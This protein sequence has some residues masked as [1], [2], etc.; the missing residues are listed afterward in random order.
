MLK[1]ITALAMSQFCSEDI[2]KKVRQIRFD[3]QSL[4][5]IKKLDYKDI[6]IGYAA[7][8]TYITLSRCNNPK[9]DQ[10]FRDYFDVLLQTGIKVTLAYS[11]LLDTFQ[12]DRVYVFN[13]RMI[14]SR[15][16]LEVTLQRK[17]ALYCMEVYS[18]EKFGSFRKIIFKNFFPHSIINNQE[19]MDDVWANTLVSAER[20]EQIARSFF[21]KRR[22]NISAGDKVYTNH[23]VPGTLPQCWDRSK[24][25]I[26]IFNSSEDEFS[27]IGGEWEEKLFPTQLEGIQRIVEHYEQDNRKHF[28]LKVH[29]N[30]IPVKYKY[31][32]DLYTLAYK[33]LTVIPADSG[34]STYTMMDAANKV[35]VF[36][37]TT[38][39]EAAYWKKAVILLGPAIYQNLGCCYKPYTVEQLWDLLNCLNLSCLYNENILKYG[40]FNMNTDTPKCRI[41]PDWVVVNFGKKKFTLSKFM[42]Y[43]KWIRPTVLLTLIYVFILKYFNKKQLISNMPLDEA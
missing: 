29:P 27:G 16:V 18:P 22:H 25:N 6:P 34:I 2:L 10:A 38:G 23:Q 30:L 17:I 43:G 11:A 15:P 20:R 12:P 3:Y 33:N 8:S 36:G 40:Y 5:D 1:G 32:L 39:I 21:E 14:Q 35:I 26:V 7:L 42:M 28:Y 41:N 13:G 9:I 19:L 37:S 24:E 4:S 31:H